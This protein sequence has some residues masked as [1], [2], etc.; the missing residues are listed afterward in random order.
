MVPSS[1]RP[2]KQLLNIKL[3]PFLVV[4]HLCLIQKI[5][6]NHTL[7]W[8]GGAGA[9]SLQIKM[10]QFLLPPLPMN[11]CIFTL[12]NKK[13]PDP[14]PL[15][16]TPNL[17]YASIIITTNLAELIV[18]IINFLFKHT[19]CYI[20]NFIKLKSKL[21]KIFSHSVATLC[22]G[23]YRSRIIFLSG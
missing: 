23:G 9:P 1:L 18:Q 8:E 15:W 14:L 4:S 7:N 20:C 17:L 22:N 21:E 6:S 10:T 12:K 19:E 11:F 13:W 2:L 16:K 3:P 5:A